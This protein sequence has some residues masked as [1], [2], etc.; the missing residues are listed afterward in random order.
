MSCKSFAVPNHPH[1]FSES[2]D[3]AA[4]SYQWKHPLICTALSFWD[5]RKAS[6]SCKGLRKRKVV[7]LELPHLLENKQPETKWFTV[8]FF[9]RGAAIFAAGY[10]HLLGLPWR[11]DAA[12]K[13]HDPEGWR[14]CGIEISSCLVLEF[15]LVVVCL[16]TASSDPYWSLWLLEG[17]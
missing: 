15:F 9:T 16:A 13:R 4:A 1:G 17:K 8:I 6:A 3:L 7:V 12:P 11:H 14:S 5:F 10:P 2:N